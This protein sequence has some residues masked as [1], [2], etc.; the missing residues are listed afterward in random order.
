MLTMEKAI[1]EIDKISYEYPSLK[2]LDNVSFSIKPQTITA[3][4]GPNGAGKS[5]L[6]RCIAA[7]DKP[8]SGTIS[9]DGIKSDENPRELQ[10]QLGY[11]SDFFGLYEELTVRQ[12]LTYMAWSHDIYDNIENLIKDVAQKINLTPLLDRKTKALSRGQRQRVAI[13]QAII[14]KPRILLLDEPA[15]G[16]DPEAR[17]DL[18]DLL[19]DFRNQGMTIIVSSHI[20]AELE[21]YSS[22]MLV[23]QNG[24]IKEHIS[25][26][27]LHHQENKKY[28]IDIKLIEYN[29]K[30]LE[31]FESYENISKTSVK[32]N[33]VSVIFEGNEE[34][35]NLLLNHLIKK[36]IP[37][38]GFTVNKKRFENIYI[39]AVGNKNDDS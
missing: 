29:E 4:V 5:T 35:Q 9:V 33:I 16:L 38:C 3:L 37:I 21:H 1:I 26:D 17:Y 39:E 8:F 23:L 13:G 36:K 22:D 18:S 12:C 10:K 15:S 24:K 32:E 11:L 27:A 34:N 19:I 28:Q 31:I 14:H 30:Y 7:L 6:L 2:A 25:L 20:L